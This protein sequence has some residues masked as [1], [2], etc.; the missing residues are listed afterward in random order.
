MHRKFNVFPIIIQIARYLTDKVSGKPKLDFPDYCKLYNPYYL[1]QT[2]SHFYL[3]CIVSTADF[4]PLAEAVNLSS[5]PV[6]S[7]LTIAVAAPLNRSI[8]GF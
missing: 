8:S 6:L 3:T 4:T 5:P 2:C 7:L 1:K